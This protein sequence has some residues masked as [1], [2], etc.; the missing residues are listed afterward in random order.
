MASRVLGWYREV[1]KNKENIKTI[2]VV[3]ERHIRFGDPLYLKNVVDGQYHHKSVT[4]I[5][6]SMI[7]SQR[8]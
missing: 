4:T 3:P 1:V 7:T 5:A 8:F 2:N 6:D